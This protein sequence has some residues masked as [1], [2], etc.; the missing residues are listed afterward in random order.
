MKN[1]EAQA[2]RGRRFNIRP[3]SLDCKPTNFKRCKM[4]NSCMTNSDILGLAEAKRLSGEKNSI[5][6]QIYK[7]NDLKL[8]SNLIPSGSNSASSVETMEELLERDEQRVKDGF[9]KK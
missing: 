5:Y 1:K 4:N 8:L 2:Q 6:Q 7:P 9:L 3:F